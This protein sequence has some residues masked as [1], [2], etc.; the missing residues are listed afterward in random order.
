MSLLAG[1]ALKEA[2]EKNVMSLHTFVRSGY[3]SQ[4]MAKLLLICR[5]LILKKCSRV[6]SPG[7]PIICECPWLWGHQKQINRESITWISLL[8][9]INQNSIWDNL[10]LSWR[11]FQYDSMNSW[12]KTSCGRHGKDILKNVSG[13]V[14][15]NCINETWEMPWSVVQ[16]GVLNIHAAPEVN[17]NSISSLCETVNFYLPK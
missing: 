9:Y 16:E 14:P 8:G 2:H 6:I 7:L 3:G 5:I 1:I 4:M 15:K 11:F 10:Y 17:N 13:M 12:I